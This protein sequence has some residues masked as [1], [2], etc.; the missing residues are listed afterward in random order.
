MLRL[1]A[2]PSGALQ[3]EKTMSDT[4][5]VAARLEALSRLNPPP[6]PYLEVLLVIVQFEIII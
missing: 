6:E 3:S 5:T 1:N 2:D 4:Y